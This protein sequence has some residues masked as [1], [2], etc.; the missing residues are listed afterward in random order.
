MSKQP[1][2]IKAKRIGELDVSNEQVDCAER[3]LGRFDRGQKSVCLIAQPQQ[4]KTGVAVGVA[5]QFAKNSDLRD[6]TCEIIW[7]TN[8]ADNVLKDQTARRIRK[9]GLSNRVNSLH[10]ADLIERFS[11]LTPS[12]VDRRLII[13]DECHV[14]LDRSTPEK[15]RP[16]HEY[17]KARGVKYGEATNSW[18]GDNFVLSISATPYAHVISSALKADDCFQS[19]TLEVSPHY[20]SLQDMR[21]AGRFFKSSPV[22]KGGRVTLFFQERLK[23]FLNSCSLVN[24]KYQNS[25][26]MIVRATGSGPEVLRKYIRETFPDIDVSIYESTP[27]NN[28]GNLDSDLS[29][30]LPKP[31]VAII[32]GSLRAGKTLETTKNIR[33]WIEPPESKTDTIVQVIGRC[34]GFE[35]I[36][37]N[38]EDRNRKFDDRFPLYCNT[39]ELDIAIEFYD[40][41]QCVPTGVGNKTNYRVKHTYKLEVIPASSKAE[42]LNYIPNATISKCSANNEWSVAET[43][44]K[45]QNRGQ[46]QEKDMTRVFHLDA[47]NPK[48]EED[49]KLLLDK[50]PHLL[51]K[52]VRV[53]PD[54]T[55]LIRDFEIQQLNHK[56]LTGI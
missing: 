29:D 36:E 37:E 40:D 38:G 55:Q 20:Y 25:G 10:H 39:A 43:V 27:V 51:D 31:F 42:V 33:M 2:G 53:I 1:D 41:Y 17:M 34:L 12:K 3:I 5:D 19:E 30:T 4:G 6:K 8:I 50:K 21:A 22:V 16:F 46:G 7:L 47:P 28:I 24:G 32:R 56:R 15:A 11:T 14:A 23:E 9:A 18:K 52:Y 45:L 26:H 35:M 49:W 44:D 48:H 54:E 13:I